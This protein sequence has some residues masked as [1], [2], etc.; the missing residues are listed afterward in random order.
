MRQSSVSPN[1][2]FPESR[3]TIVNIVVVIIL[4]LSLD[5]T[6]L[7]CLKCFTYMYIY[8]YI[9]YSSHS[10]EKVTCWHRKELSVREHLWDITRSLP[11]S[12]VPAE[13][14]W[15]PPRSPSPQACVQTEEG[16]EAHLWSWWPYKGQC[17]EQ[18]ICWVWTNVVS[19]LELLHGESV[20]TKKDLSK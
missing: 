11:Y 20:K 19:W 6:K 15:P 8:I 10:I 1:Y 13:F 16:I 14:W 12:S 5:P 3:K 7:T 4:S 9:L 17:E 2:P 18:Q